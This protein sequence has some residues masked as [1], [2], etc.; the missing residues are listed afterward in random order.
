MTL[1]AKTSISVIVC[2]SIQKRKGSCKFHVMIF[3]QTVVIDG[4]YLSYELP[5][6]VIVSRYVPSQCLLFLCC[7]CVYR[8]DLRVSIA[9]TFYLFVKLN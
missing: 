9:L 6:Y 3:S 5:L 8:Q 2:V 4:F 1:P 7:K